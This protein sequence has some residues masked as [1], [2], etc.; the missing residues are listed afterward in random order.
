MSD[1]SGP[2]FPVILE[3]HSHKSIVGFQQEKIEGETR[4]SYPGLTKREYYAAKAMQ[5]LCS[6]TE[7]VFGSH[8]V[9][10]HPVDCL[11]SLPAD[12]VALADALIAALAQPQ[13]AK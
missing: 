1:T 4:A 8:R 12:A 3:N 5:G 7:I 6:N 13:E 2:A 10:E 9:N 11:G